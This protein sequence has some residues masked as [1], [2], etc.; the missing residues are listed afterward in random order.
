MRCPKGHVT[1]FNI[2]LGSG[3]GQFKKQCVCFSFT[4]K[5]CKMLT[6]ELNQQ[7]RIIVKKTKKK[8]S[9]LF[10]FK[11]FEILDP[12]CQLMQLL[13]RVSHVLPALNL[14]NWE[15]HSCELVSS[16]SIHLN[17]QSLPLSV[18]SFGR[19]SLGLLLSDSPFC[20]EDWIYFF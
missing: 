14:P 4:L 11:A 2:F 5:C 12:Q 20:F 19:L 1:I 6:S 16:F 17:P 9:H 15:G 10:I 3:Y 18:T 7:T 13:K 8:T